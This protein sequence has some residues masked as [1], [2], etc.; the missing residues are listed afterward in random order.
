MPEV[1]W[2]EILTKR[3]MNRF[4]GDAGAYLSKAIADLAENGRPF[5]LG[6]TTDP[7]AC[8]QNEK[9]EDYQTLY[10]LLET[11]SLEVIEKTEK[12]F[13]AWAKSKF[14]DQVLNEGPGDGA[15]TMGMGPF[16][17]FMIL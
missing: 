10:V 4:G 2:E 5:W 14:G 15:M 7:D 17:F 12:G 11:N 6:A 16:Y 8:C 9:Y 1:A 3:E 13:V